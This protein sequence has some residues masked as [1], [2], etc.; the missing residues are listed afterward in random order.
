VISLLFIAPDFQTGETL[1]QRIPGTDVRITMAWLPGGSFTIGSP[2]NEPGRDPDEGPQR[3][4]TLAS[5][6]IGVHEVTHNQFSVFRYRRL[7]GEATGIE[8]E[9]FDV[10]AVA[11]PRPTAMIAE[12][13]G[14]TR[15][16][17]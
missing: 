11:R 5:F 15:L 13:L 17:R 9:R 1:T 10:D 4:V 8:G 16:A 2:E 6:W 12:R 14:V 3:T 7:D